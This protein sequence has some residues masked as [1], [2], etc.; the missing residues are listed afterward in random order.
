MS[1]IRMLN[2]EFY[3][4]ANI[5]SPITQYLHITNYNAKQRKETIDN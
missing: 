1:T 2:Y 3:P 4:R 5:C